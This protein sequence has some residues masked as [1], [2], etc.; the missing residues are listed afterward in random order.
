[1]TEAVNQSDTTFCEFFEFC[2]THLVRYSFMKLCCLSKNN[3]T[4]VLKKKMFIKSL[5]LLYC[6]QVIIGFSNSS[7]LY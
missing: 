2:Y 6:C 4:V 1:M 7:K 5:S 3:R